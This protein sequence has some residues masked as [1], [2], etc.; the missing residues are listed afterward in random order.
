MTS[1]SKLFSKRVCMWLS[2]SESMCVYTWSQ[3]Y[4]HLQNTRLGYVGGEI[5]TPAFMISQQAVST[6][7]PSFQTLE[8]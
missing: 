7:E 5:H 4:G 1:K 6:A 8:I 2:E 3:G